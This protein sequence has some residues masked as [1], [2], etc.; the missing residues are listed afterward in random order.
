MGFRLPGKKKKEI[1]TKLLLKPQISNFPV[2]IQ[3]STKLG[4]QSL[5]REVTGRCVTVKCPGSLQKPWMAQA[6]IAK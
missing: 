2:R 4:E 3:E 1:F 6:A 5:R